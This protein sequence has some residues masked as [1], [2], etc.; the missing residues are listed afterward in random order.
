MLVLSSIVAY[1][2][3]LGR[4]YI[5]GEYPADATT[6]IVNFEHDPRCLFSIQRKK[7]LQ[8]VDDEI[9]GGEI[10]VQQHDLVHFWGT[11]SLLFA[12]VLTVFLNL[13]RHANDSIQ[14]GL[15]CNRR[16]CIALDAVFIVFL[17]A[18]TGIHMLRC[19]IKTC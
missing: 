6:L 3:N 1:L 17:T 4:G 15:I 16:L 2:F 5:A 14:S 12:G 7:T 18:I 19:V 13:Y 9:H 8:N 10:V 11:H